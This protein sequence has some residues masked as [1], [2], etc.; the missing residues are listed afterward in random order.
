MLIAVSGSLLDLREIIKLKSQSNQHRGLNFSSSTVRQ[1]CKYPS[2]LSKD[3]VHVSNV[4]PRVGM[5]LIM[6]RGS[7]M[8]ITEFL[9]RASN[10]SLSALYTNTLCHSESQD[11]GFIAAPHR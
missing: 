6:P 5:H 2:V 11:N 8:I 7:A 1:I 9:I 4:C 10:N 3:T